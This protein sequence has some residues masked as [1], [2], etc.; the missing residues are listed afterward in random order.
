MKCIEGMII[1]KRR[2]SEKH[3][4]RQELFRHRSARERYISWNTL[5]DGERGCGVF[6]YMTSVDELEGVATPEF[7]CI[8]SPAMF[9][10]CF[11]ISHLLWL[12]GLRS[13]CLL[14]HASML[15]ACQGLPVAETALRLTRDR[16]ERQANE[17]LESKRLKWRRE[18]DF[19]I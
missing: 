2:Q 19:W 18:E 7:D 10:I 1:P 5:L 9:R 17:L 15:M 6:V 14:G 3:F 4:E 16:K 13:R 8:A 12:I 11:A